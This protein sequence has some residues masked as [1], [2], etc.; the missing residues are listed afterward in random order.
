MNAKDLI[1]SLHLTMAVNGKDF[2][3]MFFADEVEEVITNLCG[4]IER[5]C[6]EIETLK[7]AN[8]TTEIKPF[9]PEW[10]NLVGKK[11]LDEANNYAWHSY[12]FITADYCFERARY[13]I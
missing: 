7:K 5:L 2:Y 8:E 6:D 3:K 4:K 12:R 11:A 13:T 9:S 1:E 10:W